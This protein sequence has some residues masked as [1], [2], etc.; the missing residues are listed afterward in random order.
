MSS[1]RHTAIAALAAG[2]ALALAAV[3]PAG[4][5]A[6]SGVGGYV[7]DADT[8]LPLTGANVTWDPAGTPLSVKTVSTGRYVLSGLT[9]GSAKPL[10]VVGPTGWDR[11]TVGPVTIPADGVATQDVALHRDWAA[12]AG[13]ASE[14]SND[15]SGAAGGAACGSAAALDGDPATGWSAA[16]NRPASDPPALTIQLPQAIDVTELV[17][18][19]G[20]AC[21]HDAGTALGRYRL[22]TSP[23]GTSWTTAAEGELNADQRGNDVL[24]QL[25]GG[26]SGVRFVRLVMLSAQDPAAATI[27]V[28]ELA[29]HGVGPN[30]PPSGTIATD[31]PR[32][33]INYPVRLRA[34]F[35][36]P[37]SSIVRYLWDFDG[38]GVWDQA[39]LGPQVS[40]VWAGPGAYHVTVGA[41]DFRGALGT[42][43]LDLY[44]IDPNAPIEAV[45]QRKPLI[46]FDVPQGID[47]DT[48]IACASACSYTVKMVLSKKM[49]HDLHVKHRTIRTYRRKTKAAGIGSWTIT[50]PQ[51]TIKAL[52]KHRYRK[53][54]VQLVATAVDQEHRRSTVKRWVTFS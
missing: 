26:T 14:T 35:T 49:A 38:D 28:R 7:T 43:S 44:V 27:D 51:S 50:L 31:I 30:T 42:A 37:D 18:D 20:A 2:A 41:R 32:N 54:N 45:P 53:A 13:G 17:L 19:T 12:T 39:T 15:E 48:R 10:A 1:R 25:S 21:G 40:H 11:A 47:V 22:Q 46:T 24:P 3:A 8:G 33:P 16:A 6:A 34:T 29:V 52:R 23:D 4:A 36:D 9:P 5:S